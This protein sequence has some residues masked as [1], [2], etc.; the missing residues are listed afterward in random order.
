MI[1]QA[2]EEGTLTKDKIIIEATSGNTGIAL[3]MIGLVK[4][5]KVQIVMSSA[6]SMER[7]KMIKAFGAEI[8]ITDSAHGTDGAIMEVKRLLKENPDKYFNTN[9]Y[10]NQYNKLAHYETTAEEIWKQ[11][12]GKITHLVSS[13][14][15]SG[16]IMG[17]GKKLK[18]KNPD[19]QIIE[20]HPVKGHYI[21][22]LKNMKEAIIP[23]IYDSSKIDKSILIETEEAFEMARQIALKEGIFVGMSSGAAMV[24][25]LKVAK[26]I[27]NGNVVV[28][29]PDRGEKYLSTTLFCNS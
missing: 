13:I 16:T 26:T 25:A 2:E 3:A 1:E 27:E 22:G 17:I 24:A 7:Q 5:Y 9:Q 15:T 28:I 18:E 20:A 12:D 8:I 4:G 23:E 11:T 19:I 21:Q 14:G 6:V 10:S 29:F